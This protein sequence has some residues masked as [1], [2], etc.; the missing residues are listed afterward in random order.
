MIRVLIA[1]GFAPANATAGDTVRF[2]P[3][4]VLSRSVLPSV[5]YSPN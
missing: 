3:G 2:D 5:A 1:I 4:L